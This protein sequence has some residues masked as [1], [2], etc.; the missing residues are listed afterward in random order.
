MSSMLRNLYRIKPGD[1][2]FKI[3]EQ[4]LG[5]G[6]RWTEITKPNGMPFTENEIVNLQPGQEISLPGQTITVPSPPT[7]PQPKN[8]G[9]PMIAE[10]LAAHNKYRS[11]VGVPPLTWSDTIANSAQQ[12]ANHLAAT[13]KFQHSGVRYG[14]N[15]WMGTKGRFS[16]TQMVDAWGNEKKDFIPGQ[17]FPNVSR[18]GK[19]QDV[20][21]YTQVVWRNT[22][23]VGCALVSS[24]GRDILVCQYNLPGNFRGQK[25]Y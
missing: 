12:W 9:N 18:T 24:G 16:L 14:E 7:A 10:I 15:L 21:H 6:N 19:W 23:E 3:A 20:G 11:Q 5:D 8:N 25:A 17:N 2:L 1:T 13:G 4:Y 22:T